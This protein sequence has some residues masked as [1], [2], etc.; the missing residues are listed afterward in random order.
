MKGESFI[1]ADVDSVDSTDHINDAISR[2][3]FLGLD[4]TPLVEELTPEFSRR[5]ILHGL[6]ATVGVT[7]IG[8]IKALHELFKPAPAEALNAMSVD[9]CAGTNSATCYAAAANLDVP[10]V[11]ASTLPNTT[12]AA[13]TIAPTI[14]TTPETFPP[15]TVPPA[16]EPMPAP[17]EPVIAAAAESVPYVREVWW[18]GAESPREFIRRYLPMVP[19]LEQLAAIKGAQWADAAQQLAHI[20]WLNS[21]VSVTPDDFYNRQLDYSRL[22]AFAHQPGYANFIVPQVYVYHWTGK[23]YDQD[24]V[25]VDGLIRGLNN[26]GLR[27]AN[28]ADRNGN[29]FRFFDSYMR[30]GAHARSLNG[31]AAGGE[32]ETE[33][34]GPDYGRTASPIYDF[35]PALVK[36]MIL[37]GVEFC[38]HPEVNVPVDETTLLSHYAGD[39]LFDTPSYNPVTGEIGTIDKWDPPQE[40]ISRVIIPK[41]QALDAALGP[42]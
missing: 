1:P 21:Q 18:D 31:F 40:L 41:A 42:R 35:N 26:E 10:A 28:F 32:Y 7:S 4:N 38:R 3:T 34:W 9:I 15:E 37:D 33:S 23:R 20:D 25:S 19:G 22:G 17:P 39:L 6:A 12:L 14:V 13:T 29:P 27:V 16:P 5:T 2:R 36:T 11:T 24:A 30:A 8:G